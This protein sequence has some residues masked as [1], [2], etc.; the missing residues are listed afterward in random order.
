MY[1]PET[2]RDLLRTIISDSHEKQR[3]AE[4]LGVRAITLTRWISKESDPRPQNLRNLLNA[5]PVHREQ[6]LDL[7]REEPGFEEFSNAGLD[8]ASIEIPSAFYT[9]IF[10]SRAST[11]ENMRFWSISNLVLQQAIGQL[12]P[13]RLGMGINVVRCMPP[14][15]ERS[16]S[17]RESVGIGTPPWEG[18]LEQKAMF[19][20]AESLCGYVVTLCRPAANQ[21]VDDEQNL[22]PAHKTPFEK[23]AA[24]H[25]ILLAGRIAGCLLVSSTQNNYF[26]PQSRLALIENYANLLAVAFEPE[27][28]YEPCQI[29]LSVMPNQEVQKKYFANF[30][31]RVASLMIEGSINKQ[32]INNLEAERLVWQQLEEELLQL[33][34]HRSDW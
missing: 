31:Q 29:E 8:D 27:E 14:S 33:S 34:V 15:S 6:L 13:D 4:Q 9:R 30:R 26:I 10:S 2:W 25:P 16:H 3:L 19:L 17:L 20:G 21:D 1:Q 22:I 12:D 18:D 28:F 24:V 5:L 32:P 11:V 23:S 7:I